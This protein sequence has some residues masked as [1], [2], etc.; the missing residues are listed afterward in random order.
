MA[1][2]FL[3]GGRDLEMCAIE[4]LLIRHGQV[5]H[6][7]DGITWAR[8]SWSSY[9]AEIK[10]AHDKGLKPVGIELN[11]THVHAPEG[12]IDIDHHNERSG[13]PSSIEQVA[14]L[15]G[16]ALSPIENVVAANDKGHVKA[17]RALGLSEARIERIRRLDRRA[18]GHTA[19]QDEAA[20]TLVQA[21]WQNRAIKKYPERY[22]DVDVIEC[23]DIPFTCVGDALLTDKILLWS[24]SKLMY[25]GQGVERLKSAYSD[26]IAEKKAYAGGDPLGF[27][28][29][30]E[31]NLTE[32][33]LAKFVEQ[34]AHAMKTPFSHHIFL[35][36]FKWDIGQLPP[37]TE[38]FNR[39]KA[40]I[41]KRIA[42]TKAGH[43]KRFDFAQDHD[44]RGYNEFQYFHPFAQHALFDSGQAQQGGSIACYR[45]KEAVGPDGMSPLRYS[46]AIVKRP[47]WG[48]KPDLEPATHDLE[49]E[50]VTLTLYESG[51]AVLGFHLNNWH[52]SDREEVLDINDF[53]RR[54]WPPFQNDG[55]APLKA[56]REQ[57]LADRISIIRRGPQDGE[58]TQLLE[59]ER[60][61]DAKLKPLAG[62]DAWTKFRPA[63]VRY[64]MDR[65]LGE[66]DQAVHRLPAVDDRMFTLCWYG[67]DDLV[68][69]LKNYPVFQGGPVQGW[70]RVNDPAHWWY[71][72]V[73]VDNRSAGIGNRG[74]LH[75]LNA[76][77]SYARFIEDGSV[78]GMSRYSF[79]LLS[80]RSAFG[81]EHLR[82][83]VQTVYF[84]M[85]QLCLAQRASVLRFSEE[86]TVI[87][88]L[89]ERD[90]GKPAKDLA[91]L[92]ARYIGFVN[93][94]WFREVSP[95][96]QGIELYE[97]LQAHMDLEK[98]V[99]D[100]NGE[101][102]QLHQFV[103]LENAKAREDKLELLTQLGFYVAIPTL[104]AGFY[105]MNIYNFEDGRV[106]VD[107]R[108]L[109]ALFGALVLVAV[110]SR[111]ALLALE[112]RPGTEFFKSADPNGRPQLMLL[113][114]II[115]LV[116]F[117]P[118]LLHWEA[119]LRL[120]RP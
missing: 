19:E 9:G 90:R 46:I 34:I 37:D 102:E 18:Q 96:E 16:V 83:H 88:R 67:N 97:M 27:F 50:E 113:A 120:I 75:R 57:L 58:D 114:V 39:V 110:L 8:A 81:A 20:K 56:P 62:P 14:E 3:L 84:Q 93:R 29:I 52:T 111:F 60:F 107:L 68:R 115:G 48:G 108:S 99:K 30:A 118:L 94:I 45:W 101:I 71:R 59:E 33:E 100:L 23:G 38:S 17:L 22:G 119:L 32:E 49:L 82:V 80:D 76:E 66:P 74:M 11:A 28:G 109:A 86:A 24:G 15:L 44:A 31:G 36:P 77:H 78:I 21:H 2:V 92:K 5:Y 7:K 65:A 12:C 79:V 64:F 89:A 116:L 106:N 55:E 85:V 105:G 73:F 72:F 103:L 35:Y 25:A 43:W 6:W 91:A 95:Q 69:Q 98:H 51:V 112:R 117:M 63:H 87:A 40:F 47:Q 53:G 13:D 10:E 54:L 4:R 104:I 1:F 41:N 70:N 26:L 61:T 42:D